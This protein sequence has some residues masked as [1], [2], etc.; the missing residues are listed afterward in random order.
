VFDRFVLHLPC[1]IWVIPL[2]EYLWIWILC[3]YCD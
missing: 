2:L 1:F 3:R